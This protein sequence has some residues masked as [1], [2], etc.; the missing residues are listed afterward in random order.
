MTMA[1]Y[2]ATLVEKKDKF[3]LLKPKYKKLIEEV[4]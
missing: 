3:R 2:K 4:K 1:H